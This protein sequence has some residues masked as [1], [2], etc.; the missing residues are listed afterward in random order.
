[1]SARSIY[2]HVFVATLFLAALQLD[3]F[4]LTRARQILEG[5][6][7]LTHAKGE[8]ILQLDYMKLVVN[9]IVVF[10]HTYTTCQ[11]GSRLAQTPMRIFGLFVE[12]FVMQAA[13]FASGVVYTPAPNAR[14]C[15]SILKLVAGYFVLQASV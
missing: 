5:E 10:H 8:R 14:R 13:S 1:M 2:M 15:Q 9:F 3:I 11:G 6:P 12:P 7:L 4:V